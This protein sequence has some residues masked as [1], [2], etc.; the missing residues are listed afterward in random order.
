MLFALGLL[1]L[2]GKDTISVVSILVLFMTALSTVRG[3]SLEY[4]YD[5]WEGPHGH[6]H[7]TGEFTLC[8]DL[9]LLILVDHIEYRLC[10]SEIDFNN[11][12]LLNPNYPETFNNGTKCSYRIFR[13]SHH[14][15]QLRIDFLSF[16]LAQPTGGN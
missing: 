13:E 9:K 8:I 1:A 16:I 15:C 3:Q 5:E 14:I 10:N 6:Y 11:T 2:P 12:V 7:K 4:Y